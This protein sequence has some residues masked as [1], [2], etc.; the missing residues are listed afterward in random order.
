MRARSGQ[1]SA[2][3]KRSENLNKATGV[4]EEIARCLRVFGGADRKAKAV[5]SSAGCCMRLRPSAV[6]LLPAFSYVMSHRQCPE[7][8][9]RQRAPPLE[10]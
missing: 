5:R 7:A 9:G 2:A 8:L 3:V 6:V 1:N 4:P 10:G